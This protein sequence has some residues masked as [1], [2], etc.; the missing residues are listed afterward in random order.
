MENLN[1]EMNNMSLNEFKRP[2]TVK[3]I[4]V[5]TQA[6][7]TTIYSS[8]DLKKMQG[9]IVGDIINE[10]VVPTETKRNLGTHKKKYYVN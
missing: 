5:K 10:I 7:S 2:K 9:S 4:K 8:E 6:K 1:A 3:K